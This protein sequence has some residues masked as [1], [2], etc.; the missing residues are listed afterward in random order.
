MRGGGVSLSSGCQGNISHELSRVYRLTKG[1]GRVSV[2]IAQEWRDSVYRLLALDGIEVR[3]RGRREGF[4]EEWCAW[5][6]G[7]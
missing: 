1:R 2:S 7:W 3:L 6:S 4:L 5:W